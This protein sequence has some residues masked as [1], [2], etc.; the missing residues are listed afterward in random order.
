VQ[1]GTKYLQPTIFHTYERLEI[2]HAARIRYEA[3]NKDAF[4]RYKGI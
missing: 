3:E 2:L 4:G 1:F